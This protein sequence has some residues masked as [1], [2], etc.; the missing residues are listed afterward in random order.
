MLRMVKMALLHAHGGGRAMEF[1]DEVLLHG[2]IDTLKLVP[3]LFLTYLATPKP[4]AQSATGISIYKKNVNS[5]KYQPTKTASRKTSPRKISPG[6]FV[7][8]FAAI[9]DSIQKST[10][11]IETSNIIKLSRIYNQ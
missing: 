10:R 7:S 9:T 6:L 11:K 2:L 8:D 5:W 4:N 3:F 1:L